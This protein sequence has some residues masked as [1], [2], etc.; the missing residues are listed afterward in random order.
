[1]YRRA[2]NSD[3]LFSSTNL[4]DTLDGRRRELQAE[5]EKIDANRL[6]NTAPAD[7]VKYLTTKYQFEP[8]ALRKDD[9]T[10]DQREAQYDARQDGF[11]RAIFDSS[12]P[13]MIPAQQI[14]VEIPFNGD[15]ELLFAQPSTYTSGPPRAEVR[16]TSL[17]L[18][19]VVPHD[20]NRDIK[21][22]IDRTIAAI[23]QHLGWQRAQTESFNSGLPATADRAISARR[24]RL[25]NNQGRLATLGIPVKVRSGAPNTYAPPQVRMKVTPTLPPAST[26]AFTAEPALADAHY[27]HILNVVQG[28]AH[29]MERSP[30]AFAT[31]GEEDLRQHFLLQLNGQFEGGATGETFNVSGKTDILLRIDDRNVFIAECKFWKGPKKFREAIDQ[32][33]SYTS[34][35]DTKTSILV[36]NR[37]TAMSTVLAGIEEQAAAHPQFKR[38]VSW[39]HES[40]FRYVLHHTGDN[41]RELIVTVL[42][43][44]VPDRS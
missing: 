8:V 43:F 29:V 11:R 26:T 44:E 41:N 12:R 1:M 38:K 21:P 25:L 19:H 13:V 27:E 4:G 32:L 28:M 34:W 15:A 5:V 16:G 35:R 3:Y 10:A 24:E 14:E 33:L 31:M 17:F 23:E 18:R 42:V 36:F 2:G 37:D 40:G 6:M 7:L 30:S 20:D 39:P 22:D 9:M